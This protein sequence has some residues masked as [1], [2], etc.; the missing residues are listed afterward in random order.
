[1]LEFFQEPYITAIQAGILA[2][3]VFGIIGT[4]VVVKRIVFIAGGVS[5]ASFG[6]IGLALYLGWNPLLGALIFALS[7]ALGVGLLRKKAKQREDT[8]IGIS[9]AF[10]MAIGAVLY[11]LTPGNLPSIQSFLFGD[12]LLITNT[13]IWMILGLVI[14]IFII[15]PLFYHKLRAVSFDEE[16]SEVVG[17]NSTIFYSLLLVLT[18]ISIIFLI[19]LVGIILVLAMLSIPPSI[20]NKITYHMEKMMAYSTFLSLGF[21]LSGLWFSYYWN[22]P[23]GPMIVIVAGIGFS[24]ATIASK[25]KKR[26]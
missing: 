4:Y 8:A 3:V 24:I 16:F 18:A 11:D 2:S 1:M 25:T 21:I 23:V 12:I 13:D 22:L 14:S 9:W 15:V 19:K 26:I 20:S 5:H 17:V 10:G 7:S 6:G